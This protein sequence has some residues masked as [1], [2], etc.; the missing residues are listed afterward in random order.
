MYK[1]RTDEKS[2][3]MRRMHYVKWRILNM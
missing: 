1:C 3:K 2:V